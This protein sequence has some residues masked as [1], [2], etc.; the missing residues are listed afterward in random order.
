MDFSSTLTEKLKARGLTD[1]SV[2]LYVRNLEKLKGYKGNTQ[3]GFLISIVSS[4][5]SFKGEK[6]IDP[7]LKRYYKTM[8]DLNKSLNE[9]NHNG[10]KTET[11]SE[12]WLDWSDVEHIY[13]GLKDNLTQMSSPITEGEYNKLLDLVVLSLYVLN[14]PRRNSVPLQIGRAHV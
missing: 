1:S 14:P 11:Q 7:L 4:L 12:N 8:I 5:S 9:A 2:S 10:V 13:E 3:R 6:G